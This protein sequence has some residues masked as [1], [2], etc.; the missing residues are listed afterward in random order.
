M[1]KGWNDSLCEVSQE[2]KWYL[3][4]WGQFIK[5]NACFNYTLAKKFR[6]EKILPYPNAYAQASLKEFKEII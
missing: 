5:A 1:P 3:S 4:Y 6:S 2:L